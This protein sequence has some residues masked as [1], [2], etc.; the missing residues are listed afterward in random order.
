M[1]ISE[2]F[3][4][5]FQ[6]LAFG[7]PSKPTVVVNMVEV[8]LY[9]KTRVSSSGNTLKISSCKGIKMLELRI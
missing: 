2:I 3:R 5:S 6:A 4:P 8:T 7:T 1:E 9:K